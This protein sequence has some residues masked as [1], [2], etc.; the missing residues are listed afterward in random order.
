MTVYNSANGDNID[1]YGNTHCLAYSPGM[2]L[3]VP[4][5]KFDTFC[6]LNLKYWPFDAQTCSI[7]YGSW[8]H[9]G[10]QINLRLNDAGLDVIN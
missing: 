9:S 1:Y 8:T 5:S 2:V 3:W 7:V 6:K 4:P 10:Y